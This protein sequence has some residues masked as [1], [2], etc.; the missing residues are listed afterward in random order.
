MKESI[1]YSTLVLTLVCLIA[2][3]LLGFTYDLTKEKI[4]AKANEKTYATLKL[5][6]TDADKFKTEK[7]YFIA[8]KNGQIIG[9]AAIASSP[10]YSSV[11]KI[12]VGMDMSKKV[13]G[14]R[15]LEQTETPGLGTRVTEPEFYSQFSGLGSQEM[16]LKKNGGGVD[17]ITGA[18]ISSRAVTNGVKDILINKLEKL[19]DNNGK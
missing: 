2:A 19:V 8:E 7:D 18:T 6:F 17:G 11:L 9:Y 4:D 12:L 16:E 13:A 15:I 14:I 10:G 3:G 1:F 5:I